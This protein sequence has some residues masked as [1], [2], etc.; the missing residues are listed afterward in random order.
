MMALLGIV[1]RFSI[2]SSHVL[3][4]YTIVNRVDTLAAAPAMTFSNVMAAFTGQNAGARR[5]D[6][7]PK[8]LTATLVMSSML[9]VAMSMLLVVF[10]QPVMQLFSSEI[11][12]EIMATGSRFLRIICPFYVV[13]SAMFVYT[14]VMRGA[15]DTVVPMFVTLLSLWLVRIPLASFLSGILGPD[16]IWWSIPVAWM[17]GALCAFIYYRSG[18]WKN[19]GVIRE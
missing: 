17:V 19:R 12:P 1:N 7:I 5:F 16:G 15:G 6:R 4:A 9:T 11:N 2:S 18:R 13:F 3:V 10:A 14:G 8:G